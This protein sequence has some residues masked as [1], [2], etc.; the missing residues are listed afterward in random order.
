MLQQRYGFFPR[1]TGKGDNAYRL[2]ELLNRMRVEEANT[3]DTNSYDTSAS[4]R[5]KLNVSFDS[6]IIIDRN[7]DFASILLT[8][9]TYE[10]LI[11]ESFTIRHGQAE[12]PSSIAGTS[13][14]T[15]SANTSSQETTPSS[16]LKRKVRLDGTDTLY[17]T[18]R[19]ANFAAVG[20]LLNATARRL[21]TTLDARHTK[22]TTAELS[23]FVKK[24]PGYQA[25]QASLKLHTS[26]AEDILQ[27]TR[28]DTFRA[29]LEIQQNLLA[30]T[31][32]ARMH[33]L[34]DELVSRAASLPTVLR[35]LCLESCTADGLRQRDLDAFKRS[36]VHAYG[37]KHVATLDALEK[38]G[39][40]R[41]RG[42]AVSFIPGASSLTGASATSTPSTNYAN[43]RRPLALLLDDVSDTAP[44]DPAYVFSGYAPLSV[45]LVQCVLQ[46]SRLRAVAAASSASAAAAGPD[47]AQDGAQD[48]P[49]G[50][51]GFTDV[52]G[53]VAGRTFDETPAGGDR[54]ARARETLEQGRRGRTTVVFFLGG[55]CF[56]EVAAL[57]LCAEQLGDGRRL[58]IATTGMVG[59]DR[60]VGAAAGGAR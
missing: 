27:T 8:Q 15:T 2:A 46:K 18:L 17:S 24:L 14:S 49:Q 31:D 30:G 32:V 58:V 22:Q 39:L 44:Q 20:P 6:L 5:S 29:A 43:L 23:D 13:A 21:Q 55:I 37:F 41:A 38:M 35:L 3:T 34:L 10:G 11:D 56:A 45:R 42:G 12:L 1:I 25:E 48:A 57:R 50:W 9:L 7:V 54:A 28:T 60:V 53:Q 16:I 52:L 19:N 47:A 33:D 40:L 26:L 4:T 59:G 36:I 51:R